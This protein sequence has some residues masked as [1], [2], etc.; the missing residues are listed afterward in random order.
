MTLFGIRIGESPAHHAAPALPLGLRSP[1]RGVRGGLVCPVGRD[2]G[3]LRRVARRR[4][5]ARMRGAGCLK[6]RRIIYIMS[7]NAV[8]ATCAEPGMPIV[9]CPGA[10]GAGVRR[11]GVP[12][13]PGCGGAGAGVQ[14]AGVRCA[15]RG[16]EREGE[17]NP[18][19]PL[20]APYAIRASLLRLL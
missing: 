9:Q 10:R 13:R 11:R 17:G 1:H 16:E 14:C 15:G 19:A 3:V 8:F 2:A 18:D 7:T 6:P 12:L 20:R 5:G 4:G